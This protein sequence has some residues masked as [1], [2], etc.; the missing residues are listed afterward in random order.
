MEK[1]YKNLNVYEALQKRF[2]FIFS[3]FDNIDVYKR[4][5]ENMS[6]F[7]CPDCSK[8]HHIF[9]E[10]HIEET[11]A[12]YDIP[13]IAK[14]PINPEFAKLCDEGKIEDADC[15]ALQNIIDNI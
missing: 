9:G 13:L 6:Y 4:Q 12:K 3:E 5:V 2:E 14:L 7:K 10:S 15:D 1:I 8:E 11:A